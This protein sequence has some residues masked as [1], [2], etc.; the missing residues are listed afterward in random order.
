VTEA[1]QPLPNH[2]PDPTGLRPG[3]AGVYIA[4]LSAI[5][6]TVE[7]WRQVDTI[8]AAAASDVASVASLL[9]AHPTLISTVS[10][11][12]LVLVATMSAD[13]RVL[14]SWSTDGGRSP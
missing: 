13:H 1:T 4:V 11:D 6:G 2:L 10:K 7:P 3:E 8:G 5:G 9:D 12:H 14:G